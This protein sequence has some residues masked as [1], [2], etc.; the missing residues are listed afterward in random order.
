[1]LLKTI[2]FMKRCVS[3]DLDS[4]RL[5]QR[6][7]TERYFRCRIMNENMSSFLL[8]IVLDQNQIEGVNKQTMSLFR[9]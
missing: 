3:S 6:V 8:W 4:A 9:E 5:I 7:L 2:S 1:M